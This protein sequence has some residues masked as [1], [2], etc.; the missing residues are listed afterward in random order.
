MNLKLMFGVLCV[1]TVSCAT[2]PEKL[3]EEM[4]LD[5]EKSQ[6]CSRI[7]K[8]K[9]LKGKVQLSF[10]ITIDDDGN[11]IDLKLLKDTLKDSEVTEC[12]MPQRLHRLGPGYSF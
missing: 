3:V 7:F 6:A 5:N 10:K 9:C 12:V 4:M 1:L 2:S 8:K 11:L